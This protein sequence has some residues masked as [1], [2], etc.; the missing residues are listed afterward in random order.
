M[1]IVAADFVAA[2]PEFDEINTL[3]PTSVSSALA[4]ASSY[5]DPVVWGDRYQD[6]V[7]VK[8]A[9]LLSMTAFGENARIDAKQATA[10]GVTFKEMLR[11]LPQRFIVSGGFDF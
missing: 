4:R 1:A 6:A 3:V 7:F 10:Y 2:F 9:H 5:C 8:A 11:A